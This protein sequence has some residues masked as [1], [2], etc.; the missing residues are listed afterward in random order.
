MIA[1]KM[2]AIPALRVVPLGALAVQSCGVRPQVRAHVAL[3]SRVYRI[4]CSGLGRLTMYEVVET[5]GEW[6]VRHG[7]REVARYEAQANA[8]QA[9]AERLRQEG[10]GDR[11]ISFG[12]RFE[13]PRETPGD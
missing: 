9:V 13:S 8:L 6:I 1:S 4:G 5:A 3:T 2:D 11:P 10:G 12:M 7:G